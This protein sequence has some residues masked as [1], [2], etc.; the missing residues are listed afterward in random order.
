MPAPTI[1][2]L[3]SDSTSLFFTWNLQADKPTGVFEGGLVKGYELQID[4]SLGGPF[5]TV[6]DGYGEPGVN[7]HK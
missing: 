7:F 5:K 6:F 2:R 4:D 1:D 3:L